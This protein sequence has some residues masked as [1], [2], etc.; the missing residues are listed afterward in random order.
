MGL[1]IVSL[2]MIVIGALLLTWSVARQNLSQLASDHR[3]ILAAVVEHNGRAAEAIRRSNRSAVRRTRDVSQQLVR[4]N[5]RKSATDAA[6]V[7][8]AF[9]GGDRGVASA[10]HNRALV[11]YVRQARVGRA[12]YVFLFDPRPAADGRI[13][14]HQIG[15]VEGRR[16]VDEYPGLAAALASRRWSEQ[17]ANAAPAAFLA[18][19]RLTEFITLEQ[20][21]PP[22]VFVVTPLRGGTLTFVAATDLSG[23][24][25]SMLSDVEAALKEVA[26][27]SDESHQVIARATAELPAKLEVQIESFWTRLVLVLGP[28]GLLCLILTWVII[29]Y[30]RRS[31]IEP[32]RALSVLADKIGQGRYDQRATVRGTA[33]ELDRL[34]RSFNAMLDQ[35]VKLIRTEEDKQRLERDVAELLGLVS[36]AAGGDLTVRGE[37]THVEIRS[38]IEALNHML[39]SIGNLVVQVRSGGDEV[40]AAA[41]DILS[42][43]ERMA[44]G[45]AQQATVLDQLESR[46]RALGQRASEVTQLVEMVDEIAAQTNMLALN[47]AIEASRAGEQGKGFAVLADEVRKLAE[48]S[49]SATKDIG[50]FIATIQEATEGAVDAMEQI[51]RVARATAD[52]AD[53]STRKADEM[54][55]AARELGAA[56]AR[57]KVHKEGAEE[58]AGELRARGEELQQAMAALAD[59]AGVARRSGPSAQGVAAEVV[60]EVMQLTAVLDRALAD[61][62]GPTDA[63]R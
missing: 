27:V 38:V 29:S 8:E 5:L 2:S 58:L 14:V 25:Q 55:N 61:D 23:T 39:E 21:D 24:L 49:S 45:A 50:V 12:G 13:V 56:I 19:N 18:G 48:R 22:N 36:T 9:L 42:S 30:F 51:R 54:V 37:G 35:I 6:R 16:L 28:M 62:G 10:R 32:A 59:L 7:A 3:R 31:L 63:R 40:T 41:E 52:G 33:D 43:S 44:G 17:V 60:G 34:A 20:R 15:E 53:E 46:I 11:E 57:F 47:A 1:G 26:R 4:E